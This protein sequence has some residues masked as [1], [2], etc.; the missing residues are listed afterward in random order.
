MADSYHLAW[1]LDIKHPDGTIYAASQDLDM[2]ADVTALGHFYRGLI[3]NGEQIEI[4]EQMP[5]MSSGILIPNLSS[6]IILDNSDDVF[7]LGAEWRDVP[8]K[9]RLYDRRNSW[10]KTVYTGVIN[11]AVPRPQRFHLTCKSMLSGL[12]DTPIPTY[13]VN[14]A[15]FPFAAD[16]G[17]AVAVTYGNEAVVR[18]PNIYSSTAADS[19]SQG[20]YDQVIGWGRSVDGTTRGAGLVRVYSEVVAARP[21]LEVVTPWE[22]CPGTPTYLSTSQFTCLGDITTRLPPGKLIS[23]LDASAVRQYTHVLTSSYSVGTPGTTTVAVAD[24]DLPAAMSSV[25]IAESYVIERNRYSI[26]GV[27]LCSIRWCYAPD[28]VLLVTRDNRRVDGA[29]GGLPISNPASVAEDI[30]TS[31]DFGLAIDAG[32]LDSASFAAAASAYSAAALGT[33]IKWAL[34]GD[35]RQ[36]PA[37]DVLNDLLWLRGARL[38]YNGDSEQFEWIVDAVPGS[39]VMTLGYHDGTYNNVTAFDGIERTPGDE[40]ASSMRLYYCPFGKQAADK[41]KFDPREYRYFIDSNAITSVGKRVDR[42]SPV[43]RDHAVAKAVVGYWSKRWE[44]G[45][46]QFPITADI[47]ARD[48]DLGDLVTFVA[49]ELGVDE[50]VQIW[51]IKRR[52]NALSL[53]CLGYDPTIYSYTGSDLPSPDESEPTEETP[54]AGGGANLIVNPDFSTR[55][56]TTSPP[57]GT[58]DFESL[59]GWLITDTGGH[60]SSMAITQDNACVGRFFL[61]VVVAGTRADLRTNVPRLTALRSIDG[62]S[63]GIPCAPSRQ[64]LASL[65]SANS[66]G[67]YLRAN[68]INSSGTLISTVGALPSPIALARLD[69]SNGK[70]WHRFYS[71]FLAPREQAG[72]PT[73]TPAHVYFDACFDAPGTYYVEAF[74]FEAASRANPRVSEWNHHVGGGID[75]T[76]LNAGIDVLMPDAADPDMRSERSFLISDE[77][78]LSGASV[79]I[80]APGGGKMLPGGW[81]VR[82]VL[83]VVTETITGAGGFTGYNLGFDGAPF[84]WA[85]ACTK[86]TLGQQTT[87]ADVQIIGAPSSDA[88]RD[89][90]IATNAGTFSGG[91]VRAIS[92][93]ERFTAPTS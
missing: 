21:G 82:K 49:P 89:L 86:L 43:I 14:T 37:R 44:F 9:L 52:W 1:V 67:L 77:T 92:Y 46:R 26:D 42:F 13:V 25:Q 30:L 20:G 24:P 10:Q 22:P 17:A 74:K 60:I 90:V 51:G 6:E 73:Q 38:V 70:G 72:T 84:A 29:D 50:D 12:L 2:S 40:A 34:G 71:S 4:D 53:L 75:R 19:V 23:Y 27:P 63:A 55:F 76:L 47:R 62:D 8:V 32:D 64:Y 33:A 65:Y 59:P 79:N 31:S 57:N 5:E 56:R 68:W 3:V 93:L 35:Q 36:R 83:L 11:S 39:S 41:S 7:D 80:R 91:K 45:D 85:K 58:I 48:L 16:V 54:S 69:D 87:Q 18:P 78:T 15:D 61:T 88:D 66:S 81:E 28:D